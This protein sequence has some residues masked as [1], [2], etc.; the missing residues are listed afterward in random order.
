VQI[1]AG[2]LGIPNVVVDTALL[3]LLQ[4]HEGQ[5][6][7]LASS[8]GGRVLLAEDGPQWDAKLAGEVRAPERLRSDLARLNLAQ[9]A[10]IPLER[11]R[12][13]DAGR[14]AGPKAAK[15]GELHAIYPEAVA[16]GVVLPFGAFRALLDQPMPGTGRSTFDWMRDEYRR[17]AELPPAVREA[18][19]AVL[20]K[21]LRDWIENADPGPEWRAALRDS[22]TAVFGDADRVAVYV[23]SDTNVEDLPGFSGAGLNLTVPNVVGFAAVLQAIRRVWASPFTERAFAWRQMRMEDPEH[24]YVSVLVQRAVPVEKSGVMLTMDPETGDMGQYHVAVSEGVGGA[25]SG[26]GAE[27]WR[28]DATRGRARL[29]AEA[30]ATTRRM[31]PATGGIERRP[32]SGGGVLDA[33]ELEALRRLGNQLPERFPLRDADGRPLPAD[34]EFGFIHGRLVLFQIRPYQQSREARRNR[35]LLDLDRPLG[36]REERMVN[37][38]GQP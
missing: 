36:E 26:E 19:A 1:L 28:L 32:V 11:L 31:L 6:V 25:V 14:V 21:R 37:L 29:L 4:A 5:R 20:R 2:N 8:P 15:L 9:R 24:V 12:A 13:D 7:L 33:V 18:E 35:F 22:M 34:V 17:I 38:G 10:P 23:R 3:P 27:E 30:S 16:E